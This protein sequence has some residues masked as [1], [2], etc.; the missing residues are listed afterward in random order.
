MTLERWAAG[1]GNFVGEVIH[2]AVFESAVKENVATDVVDPVL[3]PTFLRLVVDV[4]AL[5]G[6]RAVLAFPV[7]LD[8]TIFE[9]KFNFAVAGRDAALRGGHAP[10]AEPEI[11]LAVLG[12]EGAGALIVLGLFD[13]LGAARIATQ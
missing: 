2:D 1:L 13:E 4:V 6:V 11:K 12:S 7:F 5:A 9:D 8:D 3:L 10:F